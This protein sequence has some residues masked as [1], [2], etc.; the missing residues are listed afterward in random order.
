MKQNVVQ[1]VH[2]TLACSLSSF[3]CHNGWLLSSP[4]GLVNE[5]QVCVHRWRRMLDAWSWCCGRSGRVCLESDYVARQTWQ[6]YLFYSFLLQRS[7]MLGS[8]WVNPNPNEHTAEMLHTG[9]SFI[10]RLCLST[11]FSSVYLWCVCLSVCLCV[12]LSVSLLS[13]QTTY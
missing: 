11:S 9:L 1:W 13:L 3:N 12:C 6:C 10:A 8:E 2:T 5:N 4:V 7:I